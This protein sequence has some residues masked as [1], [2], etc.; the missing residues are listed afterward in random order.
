MLHRKTILKKKKVSPESDQ[1]LYM[2]MRSHQGCSVGPAVENG[3]LHLQ[4]PCAK[5]RKG[6]NK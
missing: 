2:T 3:A 6:Q 4:F 5:P 1:R